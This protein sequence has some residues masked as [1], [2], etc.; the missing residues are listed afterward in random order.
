[1]SIQCPWQYFE[2]CVTKRSTPWPFTIG[3]SLEQEQ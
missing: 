1:M 2:F 3:V